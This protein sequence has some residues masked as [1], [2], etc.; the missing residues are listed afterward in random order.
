MYHS[1]VKKANP[2][3]KQHSK[4]DPVILTFNPNAVQPTEPVKARRAEGNDPK[5]NPKPVVRDQGCSS[6]KNSNRAGLNSTFS[7]NCAS[8]RTS[9]K[10][11]DFDGIAADAGELYREIRTQL[12]SSGNLRS[13]IKNTVVEN[14]QALYTIVMRLVKTGITLK[15][16]VEENTENNNSRKDVEEEEERNDIKGIKEAINKLSSQVDQLR[17]EGPASPRMNISYAAATAT[18]PATKTQGRKTSGPSIIIS[19]KSGEMSGQNVVDSWRRNVSFRKEN[20]APIS[21]RIVAP[22]KVVVEFE[23]RAQC[24]KTLQKLEASHEIKGEH[25]RMLRPMIILKGVGKELRPEELADVLRSQNEEIAENSSDPSDLELKFTRS[26]R[27][28]KLY[29]AV[30]I[31]TPRLWSCITKKAR[32]NADHQKVHVETFT[33]LLQCFKCLNYGHTKKHC[34]AETGACSHCAAEGHTYK[35]CPNKDNKETT[36]CF[37]CVA[38]NAKLNTSTNTKH[39]ATSTSCPC[40]KAAVDSITS[41]TDYGC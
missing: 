27:N 17:R 19:S 36:K 5:S 8:P 29:N 24:D 12:D 26:N 37:N 2:S 23:D 22:N 32:L 25:A 3:P 13:T 10:N 34:R 6:L 11:I 28:E 35:D 9:D 30:F 18:P 15:K 14:A 16:K 4:I 7:I 31:T 20:F 1:P 38:K 40:H 41:K 39:S 21:T 33:P